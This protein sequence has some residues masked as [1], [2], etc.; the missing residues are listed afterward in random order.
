MLFAPILV[1][2][3]NAADRLIAV[4]LLELLGCKVE[5]CKNGKE[6]VMRATSKGANYAM[7]LMDLHMP[8]VG[9][10]EATQ[11]IRQKRF[12]GDLPILA[13]TSDLD[14][15]MEEKHT[16]VGFSG[17]C[18]KPLDLSQVAHALKAFLM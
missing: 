16:A 9:G 5:A 10:I 13:M 12:K 2:D 17:A 4:E 3:D 15:L 14:W 18:L 6:A 7:I 8:F 1:V 11:E